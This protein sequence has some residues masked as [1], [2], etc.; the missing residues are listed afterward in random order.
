MRLKLICLIFIYPVILFGQ[1]KRTVNINPTGS[2]KLNG[3]TI[4]K[5]GE[6]YGYYGDIN[7]KVVTQSRIVLTL[8]VCKGAPSYNCGTIWDTLSFVNNSAIYIPEDDSTCRIK[9]SFTNSG[10]TVTQHQ[11]DLNFGCDFG[12][13]VNRLW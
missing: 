13:P 2:Y 8:F 9:F 12:V 3:K 5:D 1:T 11:A 7:V 6:T 10:I 4:E